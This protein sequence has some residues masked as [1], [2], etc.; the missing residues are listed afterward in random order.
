MVSFMPQAMFWRC[1][2]IELQEGGQD[3]DQFSMESFSW[4]D[5]LESYTRKQIKYATDRLHALRG[6]T[7]DMQTTRTD[8]YYDKYGVW[9]DTLHSDL[10]WRQDGPTSEEGN[11]LLPSWSWAATD[12]PKSWC[13]VSLEAPQ[14]MPQSLEI[15]PGGH[16]V[17]SGHLTK[18]TLAFKAKAWKFLNG[19]ETGNFEMFFVSR[20]DPLDYEQY[21][22]DPGQAFDNMLYL[23][24][25]H[26]T[27]QTP[28]GFAVF[29]GCD[30]V[31]NVQAFLVASTYRSENDLDA[32]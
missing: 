1:N 14:K 31:S 24:L 25:D 32:P 19:P 11:L 10:L 16:L 9:K 3:P 8:Q 22:G 21:S 17:S 12:G 18:P 15:E 28:M 29:D 2:S 13:M 4:Y 23:I 26:D 5:L 6:I 7:S 27:T 20:Y 30:I